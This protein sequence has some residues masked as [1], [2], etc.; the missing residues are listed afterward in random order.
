MS[1]IFLSPDRYVVENGHRAFRDRVQHTRAHRR[2]LPVDPHDIA[3]KLEQH[4]L[5]TEVGYIGRSRL[6]SFVNVRWMQGNERAE[7]RDAVSFLLDH[8]GRGAVKVQPGTVRL[9]CA[10][11]FYLAP[12]SFHHCEEP[13]RFLAEHPMQVAERVRQLSR[14]IPHRIE[15]FTQAP[16]RGFILAEQFKN[17]KPRLG[18]RVESECQR[19]YVQVPAKGSTWAFIQALGSVARPGTAKLLTYCLTDGR[20]S[21][22]DGCALIDNDT[23]KWRPS[24][25]FF[26]LN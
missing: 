9:A 12:F 1:A 11:Q 8:T 22:M 14:E 23:L 13:I 2:Y 16:P 19:C 24:L 25:K 18:Q 6:R 17:L 3:N 4:G 26:T 21:L 15:E 7:Y 5:Q 20:Q 10:N